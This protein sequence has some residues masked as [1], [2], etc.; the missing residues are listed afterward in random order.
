MKVKSDDTL[1]TMLDDLFKR[2]QHLVQESVER[3]LNR[4]FKPFNGP[5]AAK[6]ILSGTNIQRRRRTIIYKH[7]CVEGRW[8]F[9]G[10]LSFVS[11]ELQ[12]HAN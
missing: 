11:D 7:F 8:A 1:S 9:Y 6:T 4:M 2:P 10:T 3:I 5:L 12:L